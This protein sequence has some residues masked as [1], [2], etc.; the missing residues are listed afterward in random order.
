MHSILLS[1]LTISLAVDAAQEYFTFPPQF[2]T[3]LP[4]IFTTEKSVYLPPE[5]HTPIPYFPIKNVDKLQYPY[6]PPSETKSPVY[7]KPFP[8]MVT[9]TLLPPLTND[10]EDD[11]D[12]DDKRM[13]PPPS[14]FK[15]RVNYTEKHSL[16]QKPQ[17]R[18]LKPLPRSFNYQHPI[19]R[20]DMKIPYQFPGNNEQ[21]PLN[22]VT[23][24]P[25]RSVTISAE[26]RNDRGADQTKSGNFP[27]PQYLPLPGFFISSTTETA[28]PILRLSNEMDLDGSFSY[29]ALGADQT[30]YVQHSRMENAGTDKQE[31]VVEGSYSYVGDNGQ[32]YTVHYVADSNGFRA[33]GD[34]LPVAPPIPEI[35]QR[36]VQ[37]NLAEEAKKPP[38]LQ[39]WNEEKRHEISES[40]KSNRYNILPPQNLFTGRT[41]ES[42]SFNFA[43]N[44][45]PQ[46]NLVVSA[47]AQTPIKLNNEFSQDQINAKPSATISPQI[48]FLASQGAHL[49]SVNAPQQTIARMF[50]AEK[51]TMPQLVN[52]EAAIKESE[53]ESNKALWRWQYG[54][55]QETNKTPEKNTISRSFA[56]DDDVMINFNDMTP[57]QYTDMIKS[58]VE[59][60]RKENSESF[61]YKY[62]VEETKD[63]V[64]QHEQQ[65]FGQN[66]QIGSLKQDIND[67]TTESNTSS[68]VFKA[69]YQSTPETT[70]TE[71]T[72]TF[73]DNVPFSNKGSSSNSRS[74][75]VTYREFV[76]PSQMVTQS[77]NYHNDNNYQSTTNN[78]N[79]EVL[80]DKNQLNFLPLEENYPWSHK[81]DIEKQYQASSTQRPIELT[82][83][84]N[85]YKFTDFIVTEKN[86]DFKPLAQHQPNIYK[87][88]YSESTT[89]AIDF[90]NELRDN[91]FLKNIF[92]K[93]KIHTKSLNKTTNYIKNSFAT[94][95]STETITEKSPKYIQVQSKSM[96]EVMD[97]KKKPIDISEIMNYINAKNQFE[98]NKIRPKNKPSFSN[99]SQ[100]QETHF[101][102]IEHDENEDDYEEKQEPNKKDL[103]TRLYPNELR[104]V[105]KNY[106]VLQ[107]NSSPFTKDRDIE[108]IKRNL[109]PSPIKQLQSSN[110]P[111]LGRAGPSVKSYLPPVYA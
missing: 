99:F 61:N 77:Y 14:F 1:I 45:N 30:H 63:N 90:E 3:P 72:T 60:N 65:N 26:T 83:A 109:S 64:Q 5:P 33:T 91:I 18:D 51:S 49:P 28:I 56:E 95:P 13:T 75:L 71:R 39:S 89:T 35:I 67:Y 97:F 16:K 93:N 19:D 47:T 23:Q 42:F 37:Y 86:N 36:A 43:Q 102:P 27:I 20:I 58:H 4:G 48:T 105:I 41:P 94:N 12:D 6:L 88:N 31:Q 68:N 111:P 96:N 8:I 54:L 15:N 29:E 66:N 74:K 21:T 104:G 79:P 69:W 53:Q 103:Q 107:R 82:S 108:H 98:S 62:P 87:E 52:Y 40:D 32:T 34:H 106:K 70:I 22:T 46:N 57:E 11:D 50:G 10:D 101:I 92:N 110:L 76:P 17:M 44:P 78:K 38:H 100:R 24:T 73:N 84:S 9:S 80:V 59:P 7:P 25:T 81:N 85:S 2:Q 55:N